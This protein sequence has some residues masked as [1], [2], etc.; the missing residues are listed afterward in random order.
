MAEIKEL[1]PKNS[2]SVEG[3]HSSEGPSFEVGTE[4]RAVTPTQEIKPTV[5]AERADVKEIDSQ[6]QESSIRVNTSKVK[7]FDINA[8]IKDGSTW[9]EILE[10]KRLREELPQ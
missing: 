6:V 5:Q 4:A 2:F 8:P 1:Q 7:T 10:A 3:P 9:L